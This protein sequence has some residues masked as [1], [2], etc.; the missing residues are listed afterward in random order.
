MRRPDGPTELPGP[1]GDP[2]RAVRRLRW[3]ILLNSLFVIINGTAAFTLGHS[4]G[5][6]NLRS[7]SL[8]MLGDALVSSGAVSNLPDPAR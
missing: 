7:A 1:D 2:A 5:D 3:A 4:R 6:L 8:H